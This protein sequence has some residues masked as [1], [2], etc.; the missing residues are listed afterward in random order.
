MGDL[1]DQTSAMIDNARFLQTL[2]VNDGKREVKLGLDKLYFPVRRSTWHQ[3][4]VLYTR[5]RRNYAPSCETLTGNQTEK[6]ACQSF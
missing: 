5:W 2:Y 6:L 3:S 4:L 1:S